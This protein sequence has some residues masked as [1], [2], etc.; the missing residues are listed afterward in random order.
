MSI[1]SCETYAI[2]AEASGG[3]V[4]AE[5]RPRLRET[6]AL[7][8]S[9]LPSAGGRSTAEALHRALHN[10]RSRDGGTLTTS[11]GNA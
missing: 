1:K 4:Q 11:G 8:M 10:F 2:P 5:S 6:L 9:E 3:R 7:R